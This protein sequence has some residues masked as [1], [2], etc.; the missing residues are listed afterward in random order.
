MKAQKSGNV[1]PRRISDK[2]PAE[3]LE[4]FGPRKFFQLLNI[5]ALTCKLKRVIR[6]DVRIRK[7]MPKNKKAVQCSG[8]QG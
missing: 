2:I 8:V 1:R 3:L 4:K 5:K 6:E 7:G